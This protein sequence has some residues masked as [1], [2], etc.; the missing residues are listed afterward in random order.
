MRREAQLRTLFE[1]NPET[2]AGADSLGARRPARDGRELGPAA[3]R[4]ATVAGM[5]DGGLRLTQIH[6]PVRLLHP[7][8][9]WAG[10]DA[11][12]Q[13]QVVSTVQAAA[14]VAS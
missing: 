5:G 7:R 14:P 12:T 10:I 6:G 4:A 2:N 9:L 8:P 13:E 3:A 11:D 1:Q